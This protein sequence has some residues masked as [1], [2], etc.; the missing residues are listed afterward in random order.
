[1]YQ[2]KVTAKTWFW[3]PTLA[4]RGSFGHITGASTEDVPAD[5]RFYTGGGGSVRGYNYRAIGPQDNGEPEGGTI[6]TE[7]SS[8]LRLRFTE[9]VGA[10]LFMDAGTVYEGTTPSL[11]EELFYGIGTGLRYYSPIGPLRLDVGVPLN[12]V[13]D[14]TE[15]GVY[16][17][18]G[19]AF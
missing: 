17:S 19:Q 9:E 11:D 4:L 6:L 3:K 2:G 16:I 13:E 8:E 10:V 12:E 5:L 7:L 1:M 14:D 18:I 15:F